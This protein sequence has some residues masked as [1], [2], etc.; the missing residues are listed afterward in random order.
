MSTA[1][2]LLGCLAF[3]TLGWALGEARGVAVLTRSARFL[4]VAPADVEGWMVDV[5]GREWLLTFGAQLIPTVR[6]MAPGVAGL[7]RVKPR[8]FF[9]AMTLGLTVWN[10]LFIGAGYAAARTTGSLNASTLA[11]KTLVVLLIGEGIATTA[12]HVIVR[13]RRATGQACRERVNL[14]A[15]RRADGVRLRGLRLYRVW[16]QGGRR[17]AVCRC[18]LTVRGS[19]ARLLTTPQTKGEEMTMPKARMRWILGLCLGL[20]IIGMW[21]S[22]QA[23][24]RSPDV[25]YV[26]T[27]HNGVAEML[28]LAGVTS[29]DVVYDLGSGD[30]RVV[31]AAATRY[32][33]RGVVVDIDPQRIQEGRANARQAGVADRVRFLQSFLSFKNTQRA[34]TAPEPHLDVTST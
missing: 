1:G 4:G 15:G 9:G 31:I 19:A 3:Y 25:M 26:P 12:W 14:G 16:G 33:A 27:P 29:N 18:V 21:I 32:G 34:N 7:L 30:G 11:L 17:R 13:R 28:R 20:A 23:P 22:A 5:R 6:L 8:A 2:S 24:P 10:T